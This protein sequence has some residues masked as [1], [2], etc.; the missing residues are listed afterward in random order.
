MSASR[1]CAQRHKQ[2]VYPTKCHKRF[3]IALANLLLPH[4]TCVYIFRLSTYKQ[5]EV[6]LWQSNMALSNKAWP[7]I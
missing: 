1:E 7:D 2:Q 4:K 3:R 6:Y 5:Y